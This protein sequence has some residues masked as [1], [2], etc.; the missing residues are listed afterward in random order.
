MRMNFSIK[1]KLFLLVGSSLLAIILITSV[2]MASWRNAND[3]G[4][5]VIHD[6]FLPAIV[7]VEIQTLIQDNRN[8]IKLALQHNP[9]DKIASGLHGDH[10][11]DVHLNR[12][13]ENKEKIDNVFKKY[14]DHEFFDGEEALFSEIVSGRQDFVTNGLLQAA[15]AA[16]EG[17]YDRGTTILL[18]EMEPRVVRVLQRIH[19]LVLLLEKATNNEILEKDERY[20]FTQKI[21]IGLVLIIISISLGLGFWIIRSISSSVQKLESAMVAVGETTDFTIS[22]GIESRDEIGRITK[23]FEVL[24]EKMR[25]TLA[26][27]RESSEKVKANAEDMTVASRH[28]NNAVFKQSEKSASTAAA[29][30]EM[31]VSITSVTDSAQQSGKGIA[32]NHENALQGATA[33]SDVQEGMTRLSDNTKET[34]N[35]VRS[36]SER[37]GKITMIVETIKG[38]AEQTNLLALN[39]AIEA[40]RAGESG[41]GF[42][43]VADEV[44]KLSEQTGNATKEIS[45]MIK[46]I[47]NDVENTAH[48]MN[49]NVGL[50]SECFGLSK[51]AEEILQEIATGATAINGQVNEIIH[52]M[53]EQDMAARQVAISMEDITQTTEETSNATKS[54]AKNAE[55]LQN[56]AGSLTDMVAK[57]KI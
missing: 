31:S 37:S 42:A 36:L 27:V 39:A 54:V 3:F 53:Q 2:L 38:I 28:I 19:E 1:Q 50:V 55:G 21:I 5:M 17:N 13:A 45:G 22:T 4:D 23:A 35:V 49:H 26:S 24:L 11:I 41:R 10:R 56:I 20:E 33:I 57:F 32:K 6:H 40:A 46:G 43:V 8:Q 29:I 7:L 34:A 47:Q 44:R 16:K 30:E 52:A 14:R 51:K 25:V 15:K 18:Q 9:Q 48:L 12:I